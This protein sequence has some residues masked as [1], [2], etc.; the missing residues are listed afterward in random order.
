MYGIHQI[1]VSR[2]LHLKQSVVLSRDLIMQWFLLNDLQYKTKRYFDPAEKPS[3]II[4]YYVEAGCS[5]FHFLPRIG[6]EEE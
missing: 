2:A 6:A 5:R 1:Q 4:I 3:G